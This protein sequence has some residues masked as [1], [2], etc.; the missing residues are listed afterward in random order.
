MAAYVAVSRESCREEVSEGRETNSRTRVC[1]GKRGKRR[2]VDTENVTGE[3]CVMRFE[4]SN[5]ERMSLEGYM[6]KYM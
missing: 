2:R 4:E 5:V 1:R 3:D 6:L